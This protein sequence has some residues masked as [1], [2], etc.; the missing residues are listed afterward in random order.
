LCCGA[1]GRGERSVS[2]VYRHE[3]G[4]EMAEMSGGARG[5]D[6]RGRGSLPTVER[7]Y[8]D[9]N[10]GEREGV[11]D[12]T[13]GA[14]AEIAAG[15]ARRGRGRPGDFKSRRRRVLLG[16]TEEIGRK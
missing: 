15:R 8:L 2:T 13:G 1:K 3:E 9:T 11:E 16:R 10:T 5:R 4:W 7:L 12:G 6:D 14:E